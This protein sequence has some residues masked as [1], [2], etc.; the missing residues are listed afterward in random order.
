MQIQKTSLKKR[1]FFSM[2]VMVI[3]ASVMI[4]VVSVY[5]YRE[6][7]SD[8]HLKRL[9]RKEAAIRVALEYQIKKSTPLK[10]SIKIDSV[11]KSCVEELSDIHD[12]EIL[13]YSLEGNLISA[14][15]SNSHDLHHQNLTKPLLQKL[16]SSPNHRVLNRF[17]KEGIDVQALYFYIYDNLHNP[18]AIF[19]LPYFNDNSESDSELEEFLQ[20]LGMVYLFLFFITILVAYIISSYIT[21]SLKTVS[22]KIAKTDINKHNEK[23]V[24][25]DASSEI[26]T[27]VNAY[28]GMI[29]ELEESALKLAQSE[30]E[31]AWREMAKQV[32]HE[33]KNPLTPMRLT[34][35][36]FQQ[37][38]DINEPDYKQKLNDFCNSLIQQIDNMSAVANAFSSFATMPEGKSELLNV[39]M[40][41]KSA[42]NIFSEDYIEFA[43]S[44]IEINTQ[45]D[46]NQMI[47]IITNL[48]KNAIQATTLVKQPKIVVNVSQTQK[49]IFIKVKDNGQGIAPENESQVFE[50]KFTTNNSGMG[51]GLAIVKRIVETYNGHIEF[52]TEYGKGTEFIITLPKN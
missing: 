45:F 1:I 5:Q 34:I 19:H 31:E 15:K 25:K 21:K 16:A 9:E 10:H 50:P 38:F 14:S 4:A 24:L 36:S 22:D 44:N 33:I 30:R 39:V 35:Q 6:Q 32:A 43:S 2:I 37:R 47:R 3:V 11:L 48:V 46:K 27:L 13:F 40:V 17:N 26:Y 42:L 12:S 51:L 20:R 18:V 41:V 49:Y 52:T 29:D 23:I 8:Y 7:N 28:N